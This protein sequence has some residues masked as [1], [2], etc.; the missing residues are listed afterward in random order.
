[1]NRP[2]D[3]ASPAGGV[4]EQAPAR[5]GEQPTGLRGPFGEPGTSGT[6]QAHG[7]AVRHPAVAPLSLA[8]WRRGVERAFASRRFDA[9]VL[10]WLLVIPAIVV[11][12]GLV[13]YPVVRT[14]WLSFHSGVD[15]Q[16]GAFV[17][18]SQYTS[19]FADPDFRA[20]LLRTVLFSAVNV[21]ATMIVAL[22]VAL[23]LDAQGSRGRLLGAVVLLPWAMPRIASGIVWKWMFDAQYGTA[24]WVLTSIGLHH[25]DGYAWFNSGFTSL[26]VISA[27]WIWQ[28]VPFVAIALLA[29]L[30]SN[31]PEIIEAA[32]V[33][34]A[35]YWQV[36]LRVRLPMLRPLIT[37]LLV[38]STIWAFQ[39]FD[40][41][42]VM[43]VPPGGPDHGTE[44]LSLLTWLNAFSLLQ[45]GRAAAIA[46]VTLVILTAVTFIYL[47]FMR[48]DV[49]VDE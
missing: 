45:E 21:G 46:V 34:G 47:R 32:R 19:L 25:F 24:N 44:V 6:T 39:A 28:S 8:A 37:V 17:G 2:R 7:D 4:A 48:E 40:Y 22:L 10:P 16:T 1:M 49:G 30:R 5:S 15:L 12:F 35:H 29:G 33:D 26:V 41:F 27:A 18:I 36:V 20:A 31:S 43:T 3:V 14:I 42:F 23:V 38:M 9:K 11:M 13:G